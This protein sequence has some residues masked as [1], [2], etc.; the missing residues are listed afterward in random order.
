MNTN[1]CELMLTVKHN[2]VDTQYSKN[3]RLKKST[4]TQA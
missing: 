3:D 4:N 1:A 2:N